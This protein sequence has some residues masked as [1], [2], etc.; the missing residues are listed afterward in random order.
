[1]D[2]A[3]RVLAVTPFPVAD[4]PHVPNGPVKMPAVW[5]K[6]WGQGRVF[7]TALGHVAKIVRQKEVQRLITRGFLWAAHAEELAK[8]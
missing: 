8:E 6:F 7:Y 1:V 4:G 2:P 3:V 5:T